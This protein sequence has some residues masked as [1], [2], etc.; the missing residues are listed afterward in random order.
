MP[1]Q[2]DRRTFSVASLVTAIGLGG[3]G[4]ASP[5]AAQSQGVIDRV[6]P[7][8][9]AIDQSR[10]EVAGAIPGLY[11]QLHS[12]ARAEVPLYA[13]AYWYETTF[14]PTGPELIEVTDWRIAEWTWPVTGTTY[15]R[16]AE[17]GFTPLTAEVSYTQRFA[18]GSATD[19]TIHLVQEATNQWRWFFG[20]SRAFLDE[21]IALAEENGVPSASDAPAWAAGAVANGPD[22]YAGL[23][24]VYPGPE[25]AALEVVPSQGVG[26]RESRRYTADGETALATVEVTGFDRSA[27]SPLR[28]IE[29]RIATDRTNGGGKPR[30]IEVL[31]WSLTPATEVVHAT[32][33]F[34]RE[35][36]PTVVVT[37]AGG[38]VSDWIVRISAPDEAIVTALGEAM[39]R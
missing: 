33:R 36:E 25:D 15:A 31:S 6:D 10:L 17:D 30:D 2:L 32:V 12:D 19:G 7:D 16:T 18:D 39:A 11:V 35:D 3:A 5:V 29:T 38:T 4:T 37:Y 26:G 24:D 13:V 20:E 27:V 14:L 23:P 28:V 34:S 22:G 1:V 9:A 8:Q 21:Q